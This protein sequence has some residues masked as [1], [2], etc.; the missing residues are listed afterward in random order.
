MTLSLIIST[1]GRTQEIETLLNNL[2]QQEVKDFEV[3]I[4]DQNQDNRLDPTTDP[5]RWPYPV[6]HLKTPGQ[7]GLSRGRNVGLKQAKGDI[8]LFPDDD[9]WYPNWFLTK[10]KELMDRHSCASVTGRAA[11]QTGRSINGRF[12]EKATWVDRKNIWTTQIEWVA[13]FRRDA[14]ISVGGYDE[15]IGVGSSTPW[16][17][18][19]GHDLSLRLLESGHRT[20]YDPSLYGFH[21]ELNITTPDDAMIRKGRGYARG[22][23]HVLRRHGYGI[24]AL[25]YWL[26]RPAVRIFLSFANGKSSQARYY[27]NVVLGRF[28]GWIG[29]VF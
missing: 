3:I 21:A 26:L 13:F 24:G 29:K 1:L 7:K 14:L 4:V 6:Q 23:G 2:T 8:V 17:A 15:N 25:A 28:E 20:Y 12:E 16:Q 9:C 11:D 22:F 27:M 5:K 19:E 10:G 18:N